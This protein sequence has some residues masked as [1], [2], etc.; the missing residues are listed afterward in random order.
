[1][2]ECADILKGFQLK[3]KPIVL[4]LPNVLQLP[5]IILAVLRI[6]LTILLIVR[7]NLRFIITINAILLREVPK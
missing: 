1:M 6:G 5:I 7:I 4:Y 2:N 3:D